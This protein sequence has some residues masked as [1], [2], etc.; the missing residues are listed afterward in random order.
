MTFLLGYA[1]GVLSLLFALLVARAIRLLGGALDDEGRYAFADSVGVDPADVDRDENGVWFIRRGAVP[2]EVG[3]T[4]PEN[5]KP[6]TDNRLSSSSSPGTHPF[7][8]NVPREGGG[9]CPSKS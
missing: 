3:T 6:T 5:R 9:P 7:S 8:C 4:D 2:L 1:A